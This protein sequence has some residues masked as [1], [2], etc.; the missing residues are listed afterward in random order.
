MIVPSRRDSIMTT[1][2]DSIETTG[3]IRQYEPTPSGTPIRKFLAMSSPSKATLAQASVTAVGSFES[4]ITNSGDREIFQDRTAKGFNATEPT[5]MIA[6]HNEEEAHTNVV[7]MLRHDSRRD[8]APTAEEVPHIDVESISDSPVDSHDD[9]A[10][11]IEVQTVT[12]YS[13]SRPVSF[14]SAD[15]RTVE[16]YTPTDDGDTVFHSG[17]ESTPASR[18]MTSTAEDFYSMTHSEMGDTFISASS[19]RS[20][21]GMTLFFVHSFLDRALLTH[22]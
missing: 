21:T 12:G 20:I 3:T 4:A 16:L 15:N 22:Y 8:F 13:D 18:A 17:S 19:P 11:T 10:L 14:Y 2:E 6:T 1:S 5:L 9:E 7:Q